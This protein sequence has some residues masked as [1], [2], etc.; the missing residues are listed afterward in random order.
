MKIIVLSDTH[1]PR[2]AKKLPSAL[3]P[4]LNEA[5]AI[6][7]AGDWQTKEIAEELRQFAP[8]Y[9]VTGNVDEPALHNVFDKSITLTF[10][11]LTI[12]VT[13][14]DGKG[15]TT[16]QRA[17]DQFKGEELDL[18]IFGHSHIPL[19]KEKDGLVLFNPGSPTDKRRQEQ[20]SF[21]LLEIKKKDWSIKHVYY[22]SK[23]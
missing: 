7:H 3:I 5:D 15:K 10:H 12:G 2:M 4:H 8:V 17:L 13:H 21:G 16:E 18:L 23:K 11:S 20:F 6:I 14:G 19:Y 9:G 22:D 1:M